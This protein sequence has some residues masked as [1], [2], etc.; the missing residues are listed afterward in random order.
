MAEV[1]ELQHFNNTQPSTQVY[2]GDPPAWTEEAIEGVQ[3]NLLKGV[4]ACRTPEAVRAAIGFTQFLRS[5]DVNDRNWGLYLRI[6]E[7]ENHWV[8]DGLIG[9]SDPY[10]LLS[11]IQPNK[12]M[13][14]QVFRLLTKWHPREIYPR[15]LQVLL[16]VLQITFTNPEDGYKIYQAT[17]VDVQN[18]GKHLNPRLGQ[19]DNINRFILDVLDKISQVGQF[20][21][22]EG[23]FNGMK[24]SVG[25]QATSLRN[26]F[27]DHKKSLVE[28]VPQVLLVEGDYAQGEVP[29]EIDMD[30]QGLKESLRVANKRI[31]DLQEKV[32][33]M[34][35]SEEP[36]AT[37]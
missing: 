31:Q 1:R 4:Y 26:A 7:V 20:N 10:L 23:D 18:L 2:A 32:R 34:E 25:Q 17:V 30:D 14:E 5:N 27:F 13:L 21:I 36:T 8:I 19:D 35:S 37:T 12:Y 29:P 3:I 24:K 15:C 6:L 11:P 22:D 33:E 16:G 9:D 28:S